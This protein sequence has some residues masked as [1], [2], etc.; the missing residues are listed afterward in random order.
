MTEYEEMLDEFNEPGGEE[1]SAGEE[2]QSGSDVMRE[3][4]QVEDVINAVGDELP[5]SD[6]DLV[7]M[8]RGFPGAEGFDDATLLAMWTET[9]DAQTQ[10]EVGE[11]TGDDAVV[12]DDAWAPVGW[13]A[14][15]GEDDVN[16]DEVLLKDFLEKGELTYK[17]LGKDQTRNFNEV[18]RNAQLGHFNQERYNT[19]QQDLIAMG[20]KYSEQASEVQRYKEMENLWMR[21]MKDPTVM[22]QLRTEMAPLL[23]GDIAELEA[24]ESQAELEAA[25]YEIFDAEIRPYL[26]D[27]SEYY[28]IDQMSLEQYVGEALGSIPEAVMTEERVVEFLQN[29]L[30]LEIEEAG[31]TPLYNAE[32]E[33]IADVENAMRQTVAGAQNIDTKSAEE[34]DALKKELASTKAI[35][36]NLQKQGKVSK[37][38]KAPPSSK[39]GR[40]TGDE[41]G[42][43]DG[44]KDFETA[45]DFKNWLRD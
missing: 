45:H 34:M 23:M 44:E 8:L 41:G 32:G 9:A 11:A 10:A 31:Y 2:S 6:A 22:E 25:G 26:A 13:S 42:D 39:G 12:D 7:E 38:K 20:E 21:A 3:H 17:A 4:F 27:V 1:G 40:S 16:F 29:Q 36:E 18:I 5:E 35:V 30:H 28:G 19:N 33:K 14:R 24:P 15:I 43:K 37:K